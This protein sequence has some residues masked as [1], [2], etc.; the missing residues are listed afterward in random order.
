MNPIYLGLFKSREN[1]LDE[2]RV[3]ASS[4]FATAEILLA[5]YNYEDYSGNSF[6]LLRQDGKLFEVNSSH[7]SCNGLE[8]QFYPEETTVAALADR[9]EKGHFGRGYTYAAQELGANEFADELKTVL[10]E[11]SK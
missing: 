2:Y 1:V 9:L 4:K 10:I 11:L 3:P 8:D 5:Y 7:C 6:V